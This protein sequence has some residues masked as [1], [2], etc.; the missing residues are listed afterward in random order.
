MMQFYWNLL[1]DYSI[2][3]LLPL[4]RLHRY[5]VIVSYERFINNIT[6]MLHANAQTCQNIKIYFCQFYVFIGSYS[7]HTKLKPK[8]RRT[9]WFLSIWRWMWV[10]PRHRQNHESV[11]E[12]QLDKNSRCWDSTSHCVRKPYDRLQYDRLQNSYYI[13]SISILRHVIELLTQS[14]NNDQ[15][16]PTNR[17]GRL[18]DLYRSHYIVLS[19][20]HFFRAQQ[21]QTLHK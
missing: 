11:L 5:K 17:L 3:W 10:L 8:L 12:L 14:V 1:L 21:I 9:V 15:R 19:C 18:N 20:D 6:C 7:S 2:S 4:L 16:N 13:C